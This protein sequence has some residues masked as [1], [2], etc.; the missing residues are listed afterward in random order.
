MM[1]I[2]KKVVCTGGTMGRGRLADSVLFVGEC[3]CLW[4]GG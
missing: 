2:G 1:G 3:V 4:G